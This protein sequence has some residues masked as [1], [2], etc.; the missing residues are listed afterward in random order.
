MLKGPLFLPFLAEGVDFPSLFSAGEGRYEV[1]TVGG[2]REQGESN[3]GGKW[4]HGDL[5]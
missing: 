5:P 1:G 3:Y 2:D 4:I